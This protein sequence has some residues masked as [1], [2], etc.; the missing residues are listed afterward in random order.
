MHL[1]LRAAASLGTTWPQRLAE[2]H[3]MRCMQ[4]RTSLLRI[5][6]KSQGQA[7]GQ[8]QGGDDGIQRSQQQP[9]L[10]PGPVDVEMGPANSPPG[11]M[12][13]SPHLPTSTPTKSTATSDTTATATS[14]SPAPSPST[15]PIATPTK[16]ALPADS[17]THL[18]PPAY[19]LS[20]AAACLDKLTK[21]LLWFGY[22][23]SLLWLINLVM[24]VNSLSITIS[25]YF[26]IAYEPHTDEITDDW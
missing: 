16:S 11:R 4:Q 21:D 8:G 10:K 20:S 23:L 5:G 1:V 25:I 9:A 26:L 3:D 7:Q 12:A 18:L 22:A 2:L 6:G 17:T 14:A 19:T 13:G 15:G 24:V